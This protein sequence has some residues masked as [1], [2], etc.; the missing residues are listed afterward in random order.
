MLNHK[1]EKASQD[2]FAKL[3]YSVERHRE[4]GL[5]SLENNVTVKLED[6]YTLVLV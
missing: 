1:K 5:N 6:L 3:K 4:D 2:R